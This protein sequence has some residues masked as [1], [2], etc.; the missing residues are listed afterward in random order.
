MVKTWL[1]VCWETVSCT[2]FS[3]WRCAVGWVFPLAFED[4]SVSFS[5]TQS[6]ACSLSAW[7]WRSRHYIPSK[8]QEQHGVA[9]V[10]IRIFSGTAG[11]HSGYA[12]H[13]FNWC[14]PHL[15]RHTFLYR[16]CLIESIFCL[17]RD[18]LP[19]FSIF[20]HLHIVPRLRVNG[21]VPLLSYIPSWCAQGQIFK[22]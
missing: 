17:L 10:T 8:Y 3:M 19:F 7:P 4:H 6:S 22:S 18:S 1:A 20:T 12:S 13:M 9:S 5:L 21:V 2:H 16:W 11:R 14:D 15:L